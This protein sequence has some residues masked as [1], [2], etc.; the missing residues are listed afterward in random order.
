MYRRF[1]FESPA[2][3]D[4][5]DEAFKGW[6]MLESVSGRTILM[7]SRVLE[8]GPPGSKMV[9]DSRAAAELKGGIAGPT[10][11]AEAN[12]VFPAFR[13]PEDWD[14]VVQESGGI[15]LAEA[16]MRAFREGT[17][18]RIVRAAARVRPMAA[19]IR[20]TTPHEDILAAKVIVAAGP[21]MAGLFPGLA[22]HLKITRQA[23]GWF[24]PASPE[25]V[26]Y[27]EFPVFI[28][29]SPRGVVYGFPDFEGRGVKAA[30]HDHGPAVSADVWGPPATDDEL[31]VVG[32]TLAELLPGAAGPIVDRDI[33]LYTN[34]LA[35]DLRPDGGNE[36]IIDRLP[37]DPRI[38]VASPC[39][40]H[41]AKFASAL[42][43]ML[44]DMTLD[45][46]AMAPEAFRLDRYSQSVVG[47]PGGFA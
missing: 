39:S 45:P 40:G 4:L 17:E 46:K 2:Y 14:V 27:G 18:E 3:T 22:R 10:T 41:G 33:C 36:F 19:G 34:T 30:Q 20:I 28:V 29:E 11:G 5:S 15:L 38:I 24:A 7:P 42:G 13:L 16:A 43:A 25:S 23:V 47:P 12:A 26:R 32:T 9:A 6:R 1:N 8:A 21:W 31:E 37:D 35:A 44:A